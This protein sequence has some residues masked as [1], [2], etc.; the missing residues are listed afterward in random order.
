[1][2]N[3][4]IDE[5][6]LN[7]SNFRREYNEGILRRNNLHSSP[8]EQLHI[9]LRQAIEADISDPTAVTLATVDPSGQPS[10]RIVLLK[11]LSPTGGIVFYTNFCSRKAS[12]IRSN[13]RVSVHFPWYQIGRQVHIT[14][15]AEKISREESSEYFISRPKESQIAAIASHQSRSISGRSC[16]EE[17]YEELK[18]KFRRAGIPVPRFWGGYRVKPT[19]FEFWQGRK[20]RLHDRF[21][22]TFDE[23]NWS[24]VRLSP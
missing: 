14:G 7:F 13:S 1:M 23:E 16:L 19:T 5:Q 20:N 18:S 15:I 11:K 22:Y 8:I 21:L 10:Q 9:W 12:Q 4:E 17:K 6:F 24:I 2:K 3:I